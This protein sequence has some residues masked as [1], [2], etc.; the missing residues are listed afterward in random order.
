MYD[1]CLNTHPIVALSVVPIDLGS[2]FVYAE[3][4]N[5]DL[6]KWDVGNVTNMGGM[7]DSASSFNQTWCNPTWYGKI[8]PGD[9]VSSKGLMK[10]CGAGKHNTQPISK[11]PYITCAPCDAGSFT[12]DLNIDASCKGC[13]TGWYNEVQKQP[14]CFPCAPG[15]F[16]HVPV[17][18]RTAFINGCSLKKLTSVPLFSFES[19]KVNIKM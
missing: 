11:T 5:R 16:E 7:F 18:L 9:F 3:A 19:F 10:C 12:S 17:Q 2:V 6:S 14:F 4:F 15:T 8:S 13:P 1:S